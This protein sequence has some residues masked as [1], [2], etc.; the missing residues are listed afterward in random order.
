MDINSAVTP[1]DPAPTRN[2][3]AP[4]PVVQARPVRP[5][6]RPFAAGNA[7]RPK[8]ARGKHAALM[9]ALFSD[10]KQAVK[11]IAA[12]VKGA[13]LSG[14]PWACELIMERM[15]PVPKGRVVNFDL[16]VL[17]TLSDVRNA[18]NAVLQA[19]SNGLLTLEEAEAVSS[20]I[21]KHAQPV[22]AEADLESRILSLEAERG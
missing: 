12:V 3:V 4:V 22:I 13:A 8:G 10:D 19:V 9:E 7:G 16:P 11:D 18:M 2:Q 14:K 17:N 21:S 6:G 5:R 1:S 20:M 15:W